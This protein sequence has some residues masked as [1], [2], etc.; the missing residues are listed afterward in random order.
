M[1]TTTQKR[2]LI[3]GASGFIGRYLVDEALH[4]GYEVWAGVRESSSL[5]HLSDKRIKFID[6]DYTSVERL[7]AQINEIS[8][9]GEPTWHYVIHNA[10]LTKTIKRKDFYR[11]NGTYTDNLFK[12]LAAAPKTPESVVLMSSLSTYGPPISG[13]RPM[14]ADDPQRPN[15][16][17][18]KSKLEGEKALLRSGLPYSIMLLTGVYGPGDADYLMAVRE[19]ARGLNIQAGCSPQE[20]TF[21]YA[22]D[23]AEA[24]FHVLTHPDAIG[25]RFMLTDG[26]IYKD[27]DFGRI[28]QKLLEKKRIINLR[29]PLPIVRV[30]C[31][32]G[33]IVGKITGKVT[34]LNSD[35]YRIFAQRSWACDDSPIRALGFMPKVQLEEGFRRVIEAARQEGKL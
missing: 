7:S 34:P 30:A 15:T 17:Y 21:V 16:D 13:D 14:R 3:T 29:M 35:K 10:G 33:D 4:Q 18:G 27:H 2:I 31:L 25:G 11:V 19:I 1:E 22:S 28:V 32:V 12:A 5:R 26:N 9:A 24:T 6:L 20:I 23:V 8:H